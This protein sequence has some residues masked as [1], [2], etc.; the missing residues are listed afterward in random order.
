MQAANCSRNSQLVVAED[1]L[2]KVGGKQNKIVINYIVQMNLSTSLTEYSF[3]KVF[4]LKPL[5]SCRKFYDSS[6]MQHYTSMHR[7]GLK[8]G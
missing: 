6:E 5:S 2:K 1:D 4:I 8:H 7:E 3:M